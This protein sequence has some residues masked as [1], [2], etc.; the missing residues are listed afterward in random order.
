MKHIA[1]SPIGIY[2]QINKLSDWRI[3]IGEFNK[4]R[5]FPLG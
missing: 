5:E 1:I 2:I 4:K 3:T